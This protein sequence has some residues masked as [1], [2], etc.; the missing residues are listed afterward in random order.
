MADPRQPDAR[1][2]GGGPT[3]AALPDAALADA[4][5]ALGDEL[6]LPVAADL[7]ERV[8][9]RVA[10]LPAPGRAP[11]WRRW[12]AGQTAG[13]GAPMRRA[14]VL[15][16]ALLLVVVAAVG[17]ATLGLPGLQIQFGPGPTASP[18]TG[19]ATPGPLGDGLGLGDPIALEGV[20]A[21]ASFHVEVPTDKRLG[22]PDAIAWDRDL[23]RG[24]V[25]LVWAAAPRLPAIIG[26]TVGAIL[27]ETPGATG[28]TYV[29]KVLGPDTTY[30]PVTVDG[31]PGL[32]ISGEPHEFMFVTP[33]GTV[34]QDSRRV[35]G[36]TLTW[37]RD[38][39]LYRFESALGKAAA[40]EVAESME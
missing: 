18:S 15:G 29:R 38:G 1:Q 6:E 25:A 20:D 37:W 12:S 27:T 24:Q 36:D 5:R 4:L 10:T 11:W 7:P 39:I 26:D 14:S 31:A 34:V 13:H 9:A 17:A 3:L 22:P 19:P 33:E 35:V 40:I 30:E 23:G 16:V 21:V 8:R 2:A 28:E 32:W